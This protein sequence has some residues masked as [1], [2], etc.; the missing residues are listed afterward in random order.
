MELFV[1]ASKQGILIW[2]E[3]IL[4]ALLPCTILSAIL[5]KSGLLQSLKK[6]TSVFA[7]GLTIFFGFAFGFPI[8]AKLASDFHG[9]GFLSKKEAL[10]L[11]V[12]TNNFS[13]PYV[14]GFV[15][16]CLFP[17][18]RYGKLLW[19]LYLVPAACLCLWFIV[20]TVE[21][22]LHGKAFSHGLPH[23]KPASRFQLNMQIIDAGIISGFESLIK[24]CGYIV[25]FSLLCSF[26][27]KLIPCEDAFGIF[28][29]GNLEITNGIQLLQK[30]ASLPVNT[31]LLLAMQL[32]SFGGFS[33][34]AQSASLLH[35]AKLPTGYYLLGKLLLSVVT[36][37]V[38]ALCLNIYN[39]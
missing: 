29:L 27:S 39:G 12:F 22:R 30:G 2:F 33:G 21:K 34:L 37:L 5:L 38:C 8:G 4:P 15:L 18:D 19:L 24:I 9:H 20:D 32:L 31:K 36:V 17:E 14:L 10:F 6:H 28:L 26:A 16:P 1:S 13:M 11:A 7:K 23:K 35:T 3:Q 25:L